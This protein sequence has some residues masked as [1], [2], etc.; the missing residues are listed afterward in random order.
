[1]SAKAASS[2][3]DEITKTS[4]RTYD[5]R[6]RSLARGRFGNQAGNH[7]QRLE[8]VRIVGLDLQS[9]PQLLF[10][11]LQIAGTAIDQPQILVNIAKRF[12]LPAD[13]EGLLE[14]SH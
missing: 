3:C 10:T 4:R 5:E 1:M 2:F 8:D 6:A 11:I 7:L 12:A 14:V 13:L 9:Q